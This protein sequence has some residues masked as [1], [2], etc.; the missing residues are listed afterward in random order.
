MINSAIKI[1]E[2]LNSK[3]YKTL[4]AGGFVRDRLMG[5]DPKDIDLATVATPEQMIQ[6]FKDNNI[7]YIETGIKHGT[8]TA[9]INGHNIEI[10]TLRIDRDCDGRHATVEFTDDFRADAS[11]RDFTINAMFMD[12]ETFTVY[13]YFNG[14]DDIKNHTIR[15]VGNPEERIK[16]D[17]LRMLRAYRFASVL[18]F[19]VDDQALTAID[20]YADFLVYVSP[21][22]IRDEFLKTLEGEKPFKYPNLITR[23]LPELK[24][25]IKF[26][27]RNCHH[28]YDVMTHSIKVVENLPQSSKLF[29]EMVDKY[30]SFS[31]KSL[32][33]FAGLVHDIA[34]PL[35]FSIDEE[36][37]GHFYEHHEMAIP[38]IDRICDR[39]KFPNKDKEYIKFIV[40]HHMHFALYSSVNK[41]S[42]RKLIRICEEFSSRNLVWDLLDFRKADLAGQSSV[43]DPDKLHHYRSLVQLVQE[44]MKETPQIESPLNGKEIMQITGLKEGKEIGNIK[45]QLIDG[46]ISGVIKPGDR[47]YCIKMLEELKNGNIEILKD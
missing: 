1:S 23:I 10:T 40:K 8:I 31:D 7:Y 39:L 18:D 20:K 33:R 13:D 26:N 36:G 17:Y 45:N 42:V 27:Q 46:V 16:E 12:L 47:N 9:V 6:V 28:Q 29:N 43:Y 5:K 4:A 38:I 30:I 19:D 35:S 32:L 41:R 2:L 34:K 21:E 3:G 22:R 37:N 15:F 14:I 25:C 24:P 11:R 44:V